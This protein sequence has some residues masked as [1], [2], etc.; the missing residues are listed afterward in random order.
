MGTYTVQTVVRAGVTPTDNAVAS[1]DEFANDGHTILIVTNGSGGS[2]TVTITTP[3]TVDGLAVADR[4]VSIANG[5]KKAIGP[6]T[7]SLYNDSDG[8]VT[9]GYSATTSVTAMCLSV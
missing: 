1:S 9:V 5:A 7:K 8:N 6:F 3:G 4:T 2:L